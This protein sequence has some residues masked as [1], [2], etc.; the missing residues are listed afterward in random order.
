MTEYWQSFPL[1]MLSISFSV[2]LAVKSEAVLTEKSFHNPTDCQTVLTWFWTKSM[3]GSKNTHTW[4]S[5]TLTLTKSG[6]RKTLQ[7]WGRGREVTPEQGHAV[8]ADRAEN[9]LW[10]PP[11]LSPWCAP[12]QAREQL[13]PACCNPWVR[14]ALLCNSSVLLPPAENIRENGCF[15]PVACIS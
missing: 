7:K 13:Q 11:A 2:Q 9:S 15:R 1:E 8:S 5:L 6:E 14:A 12:H 3:E 10:V 4:A